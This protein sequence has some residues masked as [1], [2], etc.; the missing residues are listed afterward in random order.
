MA[1]YFRGMHLGRVPTMKFEDW[2]LT[3]REKFSHLE[4]ENLMKQNTEGTVITLEPWNWLC[5]VEKA[6]LL[7]LLLI[8]HFHCTPITIFL[9][10]QLLFLAHDGYLWLEEPIPIMADLTHHISRLPCKGKDPATIAKGKGINL[11]LAEAMKGKYKLEK[12]KR[13]YSISSIK[14]KG[15]R[16]VT[17]L[18][19]GKVMR[20]CSGDDV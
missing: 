17:Q 4:T 10:R 19:V 15:V 5:I 6:G 11:A 20:K 16:V 3:G 12:K 14:E 7:H 1:L 13:G 18:L 9:I 8:P 2:D